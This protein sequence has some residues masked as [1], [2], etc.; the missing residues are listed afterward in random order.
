MTTC[1]VYFLIQDENR[2]EEEREWMGEK[3][4]IHHFDYETKGKKYVI[5]GLTAGIL[6]RAASVVYQRPP[7]FLEQ[8]P[9]FKVPRVVDKDTVMP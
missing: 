3:Y 1:N 6:I 5:W 2:S 7:A 4:L 8:N 9:K